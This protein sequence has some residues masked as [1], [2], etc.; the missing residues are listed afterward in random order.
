MELTSSDWGDTEFKL[1]A[2]YSVD[3]ED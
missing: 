1:T 3:V 2:T